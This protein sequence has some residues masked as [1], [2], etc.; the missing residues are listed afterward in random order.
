MGIPVGVLG[1]DQGNLGKWGWIGRV[2]LGKAWGHGGD[3]GESLL[4]SLERWGF[5]G[6]GMGL[7]GVPGELWGAVLGGCTRRS[8]LSSSGMPARRRVARW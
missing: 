1:G 8:L 3:L 7:V 2:S 4:E 5:L 6:E